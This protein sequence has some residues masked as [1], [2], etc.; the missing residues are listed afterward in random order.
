MARITKYAKARLARSQHVVNVAV[1][2][3]RETKDYLS[4]ACKFAKAEG[5]RRRHL[6]CKGTFGEQERENMFCL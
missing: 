2:C 1:V 3:S 6:M 5:A 4:K